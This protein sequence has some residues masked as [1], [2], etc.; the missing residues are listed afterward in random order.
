M[1][2]SGRVFDLQGNAGGG[3]KDK[4]GFLGYGEGIG[5]VVG[6]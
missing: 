2:D 1:W 3:G 4:S 5:V 6:K